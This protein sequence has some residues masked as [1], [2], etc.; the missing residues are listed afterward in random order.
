M[1]IHSSLDWGDVSSQLRQIGRKAST[2][3]THLSKYLSTIDSQ[4]KKLGNMEVDCRRMKRPPGIQYRELVARIN[5]S[6]TEL[7]MHLMI[8]ALGK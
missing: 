1:E 3:P 7:E 5:E 8:A 6:I 2:N 4:V